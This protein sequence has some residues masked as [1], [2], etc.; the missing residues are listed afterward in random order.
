LFV[1]RTN[2]HHRAEGLQVS[3]FSIPARLGACESANHLTENISVGF[4]LSAPQ[5]PSRDRERFVDQLRSPS[6]ARD[7]EDALFVRLHNVDPGFQPANLLTA[8]IALPP[9][10][11]D[12]DQKKA[13]FFRELL[14]RVE[15]LPGVHGAAM[16]MSLPAT[17]WIRT[18]IT[19]VEG[20]PSPDP[21]EASS[22]GVLQSITPGSW[23]G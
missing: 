20:K 15:Q 5:G 17:A 23:S 8:K 1:A 18:D 7:F 4:S 12:T 22:F 6:P 9:A 19:E 13:A 11:Y 2:K 16:A 10:R 14:P 3:V 21:A